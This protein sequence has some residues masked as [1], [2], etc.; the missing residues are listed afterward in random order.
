MAS[1]T[2][3]YISMNIIEVRGKILIFL[4]GPWNSLLAILKNILELEDGQ[5]VLK[6][7]ASET[8][9]N[10]DGGIAEI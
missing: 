2:L 9:G 6:N 4:R 7:P 1:T 3:Q 8:I 5:I 10:D